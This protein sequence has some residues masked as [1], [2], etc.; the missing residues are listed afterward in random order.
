MEERELQLPKIRG[1]TLANNSPDS[2][3]ILLNLIRKGGNSA[4]KVRNIFKTERHKGHIR[5]AR[6]LTDR[7]VGGKGLIKEL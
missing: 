3:S 6:N 7:E 5:R 1:L 4:S 2:S